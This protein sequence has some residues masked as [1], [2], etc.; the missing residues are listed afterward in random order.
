MFTVSLALAGFSFGL[1][2]RPAV[3]VAPEASKLQARAKINNGIVRGNF[4]SELS[5]L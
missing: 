1:G 4:I 3:G 2:F 5:V